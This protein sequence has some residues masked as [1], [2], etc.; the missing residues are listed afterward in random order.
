MVEF[1]STRCPA[2]EHAR[3]EF[4]RLYE[5]VQSKHIDSINFIRVNGLNDRDLII[6]YQVPYYP[7]LLILRKGSTSPLAAFPNGM[8]KLFIN[9]EAWV[10]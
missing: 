4:E 8:E 2:C 10:S 3:L 1:F 9:F 7:H 5:W 6:K